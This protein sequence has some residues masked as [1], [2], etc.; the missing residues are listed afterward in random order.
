METQLVRLDKPYHLICNPDGYFGFHIATLMV[1][2]CSRND[3]QP[4]VRCYPV[5][6]TEET[7][8]GQPWMDWQLKDCKTI[9]RQQE[10]YTLAAMG[11]LIYDYFLPRHFPG[12]SRI[13]YILSTNLKVNGLKIELPKDDCGHTISEYRVELYFQE[14][15]SNSMFSIYSHHLPFFFYTKFTTK[16]KAK[17]DYQLNNIDDAIDE[18]TGMKDAYLTTLASAGLRKIT[19][20]TKDAK[21]QDFVVRLNKTADSH[22]Q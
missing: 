1:I 11:E 3:E 6:E 8:G 18:L 15:A 5:I 22:G 10:T 14:Y 20:F 12:L 2:N 7:P 13:P 21:F 16:K 9:C 4:N 17:D 19:F